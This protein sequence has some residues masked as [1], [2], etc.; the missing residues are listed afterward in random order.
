MRKTTRG[1]AKFFSLILTLLIIINFLL[2]NN[3]N[4]TYADQKQDFVDIINYKIEAEI[5]PDTHIL[6]A[7]TDVTFQVLK[8]TQSVIF[9]MNG[10]LKVSKIT[11][12]DGRALQFVQDTVDA[13]NVRIDL[14]TQIQANQPTTLKF[15][16][17]GPDFFDNTKKSVMT[18]SYPVLGISDKTLILATPRSVNERPIVV[19]ME[20]K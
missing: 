5:I 11:T 12:E 19:M 3:V 2:I 6:K 14:G 7:N 9:E 4:V 1:L 16:Y 18:Y 15:T 8:P 13:L 10:S 20:A 17:E